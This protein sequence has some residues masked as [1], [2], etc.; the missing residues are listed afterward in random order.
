VAVTFV[1]TWIFNH[2]GDSAFMTLLTHAA[3]GTIALGALGFVAADESR[4]TALY[5][6]A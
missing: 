5:A 6:A 4:V 2:T 1:Y 3:E